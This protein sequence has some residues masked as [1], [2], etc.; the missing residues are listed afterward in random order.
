MGVGNELRGDD[1]IGVKVAD[2]LKEE[3]DSSR[4]LV[5]NAG[6]AP[7]GFTSKITEFNPTHLIIIDAVDSGSEPGTTTQI[8]LDE[9]DD[10]AISTHKLPLSMLVD[11]L[12]EQINLEI[13]F[14]GVQPKQVRMGSEMT[15]EIEESI[16]ELTNSLI[17]TL[18][19]Q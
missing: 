8:D 7:E 18:D 1:A 14:I 6:P 10:Q 16:E 13:I 17:E 3:L 15:E 4:I 2:N 12:N 9:I 19:S 11:F 5:I